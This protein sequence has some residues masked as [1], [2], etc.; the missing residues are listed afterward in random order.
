MG[1][2]NV[3]LRGELAHL[4]RTAETDE[5]AKKILEMMIEQS[6]ASAEKFRGVDQEIFEITMTALRH[7]AAKL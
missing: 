2:L 6:E 4:R 1:I 5:G 3:L 7:A